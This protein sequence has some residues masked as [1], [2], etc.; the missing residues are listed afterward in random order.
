[1]TRFAIAPLLLILLASA[2]FAQSSPAS[3]TPA[4]EPDCAG[5]ARACDRA[6]DELKVAR[7][8]IE[9]QTAQIAA[10][11]ARLDLERERATLAK[12]QIELLKSQIANLEKA[13][14]A[15]RQ[16]GQLQAK[17]AAEHQKRAEDLEKRLKRSKAFNRLALIAGAVA[18]IL[19]R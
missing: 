11:A 16:A 14:D 10:A 15:E 8:L 17:L 3:A 12:E 6:A 7:A 5:L 19:A 9:A 1:M 18:F 2:M 13:I 4:N